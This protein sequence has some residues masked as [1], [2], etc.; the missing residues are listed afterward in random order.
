[1]FKASKLSVQTL[2]QTFERLRWQRV[3]ICGI[4]S[5]KKYCLRKC[6]Q[7]TCISLLQILQILSGF[8]RFALNI[9]EPLREPCNQKEIAQV[10][11][12]QFLRS[13]A[14]FPTAG[15]SITAFCV[16]RQIGTPA[17]PDR[18]ILAENRSDWKKC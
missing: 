12:R 4:L 11:F 3:E 1:M 16:K 18:K 7:I 8:I 14:K 9:T 13:V 2:A 5:L 6:L 10:I 17:W 15:R